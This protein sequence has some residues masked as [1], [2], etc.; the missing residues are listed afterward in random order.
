MNYRLIL[1]QEAERDLDQ[2]YSWYNEKVPGLGSDFLVVVERALESIQVNP[3]R[4]PIVYRK[5]H[6][7][8]VRRF[9]YGIFFVTN[10][11]QIAILAIMHTARD[12]DKWRQP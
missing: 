7:A 4:F 2:A 10:G 3:A 8:L 12:P 5:V 11:D 9:P 6:R 1:R